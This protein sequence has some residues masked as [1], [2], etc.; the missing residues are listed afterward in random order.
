M[1][2]SQLLILQHLRLRGKY[3]RLSPTPRASQLTFFCPAGSDVT[4]ISTMQR[5]TVNGA[6]STQGHALLVGEAR[7]MSAHEAACAAARVTFVPI[8]METLGGM[9]ALTVD[10]LASLGCLL[11][12]R[13]GVNPSDSVWHLFQLPFQYGGVTLLYGYVCH[14]SLPPQW[15]KFTDIFSL[16]LPFLCVLFNLSLLVNF[17]AFG[18]LPSSFS[19]TDLASGQG[20]DCFFTK[21]WAMEM[22]II[23]SKQSFLS[24]SRTQQ[25]HVTANDAILP[26]PCLSA[27][28]QCQ[29]LAHTRSHVSA[30]T[31]TLFFTKRFIFFIFV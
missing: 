24:C 10:T 1:Q 31:A 26:L 20:K 11:G 30:S 6:A 8:V 23:T 4:V 18:T 19:V 22:C 7:K 12:Q 25:P 9:S 14:R 3:H 17:L 2:S 28:V 29:F 13:L 16:S 5:A 15:M 21:P 27:H